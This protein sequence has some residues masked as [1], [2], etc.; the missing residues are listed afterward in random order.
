MTNLDISELINSN[1]FKYSPYNTLTNE[2]NEVCK[3]IIYDMM[4]KLRQG[5]DATS[6]ISGGAG[7]GVPIVI[8]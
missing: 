4:E 3:L 6:I 1:L 5:I 7:T 2:Q 8:G